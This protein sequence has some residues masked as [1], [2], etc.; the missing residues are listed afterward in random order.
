MLLSL[1]YRRS[2]LIASLLR[3]H[4][5]RVKLKPLFNARAIDAPLLV[6][7]LDGWAGAPLNAILFER[8]VST[9]THIAHSVSSLL[10]RKSRPYLEVFVKSA[11][12]WGLALESFLDVI[13][14]SFYL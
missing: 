6:F 5:S 3:V 14:L 13:I 12:R 2:R 4:Q 1:D 7:A 9:W 10:R 11:W 8:A